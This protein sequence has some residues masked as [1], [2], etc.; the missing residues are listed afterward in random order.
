MELRSVLLVAPPGTTAIRLA[1]ERELRRR[2]WP[3]ACSPAAADLLALC[4]PLP[5][6]APRWLR[7][8]H[9]QLPLPQ[10]LVSI[11]DPDQA[12]TA[13]TARPLHPAR[14]DH[15]GDT[16]TGHTG[17]AGHATHAGH[18]MEGMA[19][20][21]DDR[22]GLRLDRWQLTWGPGLA[23]WPGGL[24]LRVVTQG[25]VIQEAEADT[26]AGAPGAQ[27]GFGTG[28]GAAAGSGAGFAYWNAPWMR[29]A[30]GEHVTYGEAA[31]RR[32]A[33]HLDSL[34]R[35]LA[36]AGWPDP[37]GRARRLR[38]AA[39]QRVPY[40]ATEAADAVPAQ[41]R[42]LTSGLRRSR[43]LRWLTRGLGP[44][45]TARARELGITGP[46]LVAAVEGAG[47]AYDRIRV[48]LDA[49]DRSADAF[50]DADPLPPGPAAGPRGA[51]G[52]LP[53]SAGLLAAVPELLAGTEFACARLVLASL[54]P[55]PDELVSA[56]SP[57]PAAQ[58]PSDG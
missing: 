54:D 55:D 56:H 16:H 8:L 57:V 37:A 13:L 14:E 26:V 19:G 10:R 38:D 6:P 3:L 53:P 39:L 35:L 1:A 20:R 44:L 30:R 21:G 18:A 49:A 47:E 51:L 52:H 17:H 12:A 50:A 41:V 45:P 9:S 23:D 48:W 58:G 7:T 24:L 42:A 11:P 46:A 32:C 22:D 28:A 34:G 5:S 36:V 15:P 31:R 25:D 33:A 4:G 2:A 40:G 27:A 29:A 43:A